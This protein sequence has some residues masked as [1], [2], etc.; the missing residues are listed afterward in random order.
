MV[1][2]IVVAVVAFVLV[3]LL[4]GRGGGTQTS[5]KTTPVVVAAVDIPAGTQI[6]AQVVTTVNYPTELVPLGAKST[7]TCPKGVAGCVEVVG[8]YAAVS[9]SKNTPLTDSILVTSLGKLP[10]VKKPYLDIPAGQV[11]MSIP[12]GGE[13]IAVGGFIQPDDRVDIMVSGMPDQKAGSWKIILE[14]LRI[15]RTGGVASPNGQGLASSY[16][17]YVS[18]DDAEALS[19][20]FTSGTYKY[21]LKSQLDAKPEDKIVPGTSP[22]INKD[23]FNARFGVPK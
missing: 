15:V 7:I 21:V 5:G 20:L 1:M 13:L 4:G 11:A 6:S 8:E 3:I 9:I 14:N 23:T 2:G 12:A 10:P 17:V 22:G 19:Y 18:K 16:M